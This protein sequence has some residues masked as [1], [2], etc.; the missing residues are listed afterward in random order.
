MK[1]ALGTVQFGLDYGIANS[2]GR[3]SIE[4]VSSILEIAKNSG[5]DTLDTAISYGDSEAVLGDAGIKQFETITKLPFI[6]CS[7]VEVEQE[8]N[9]LVEGS[10]QRLKL[11]RLEGLLLHRPEQLLG[12]LG[13]EIYLTLLAL[14]DKGLVNKIG[15]SIYSPSEL[16]GIFGKF[17]IDIVQAPLSLIDRRLIETGWL[18]R[19]SGTGIEVHARSVFLQG[20][21]LM[22]QDKIPGKFTQWKEL[23]LRWHA[24]LERN[25]DVSKAQ[26]CIGYLK[27]ITEITKIVVGVDTP[28]QLVEL[29][30]AYRSNNIKS[31]DFPN[32]SCSDERLVHPSNWSSL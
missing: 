5:V 22:Q 12:D 21:L 8:I 31:L 20:L 11:E 2:D 6:E 10:L 24:W 28:E 23:I 7:K 3:P 4:S 15:V 17:H 25:K 18:A 30:N 27:S 16:E 14:R 29:V 32:I 26:A 9:N 1:L 13:N 19:L